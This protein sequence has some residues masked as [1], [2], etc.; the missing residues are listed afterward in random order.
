MSPV[1]SVD[2]ITATTTAWLSSRLPPAAAANSLQLSSHLEVKPAQT[3]QRLRL[4]GRSRSTGQEL[5]R[6]RRGFCSGA[7]VEEVLGA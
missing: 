2:I 3:Y 1:S 6:R 7:E 4:S 5:Q